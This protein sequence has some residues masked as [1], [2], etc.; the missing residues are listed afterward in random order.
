LED[1][2]ET[3]EFRAP[4]RRRGDD[5]ESK[6]I[7]INNAEVRLLKL[8]LQETRLLR[9]SD[10]KK[11][12]VKIRALKEENAKQTQALRKVLGEMDKLRK[13]LARQQSASRKSE[14]S[15]AS[16]VAEWETKLSKA[17]DDASKARHRAIV[18][19]RQVRVLEEDLENAEFECERDLREKIAELEANLAVAE[20]DAED[21]ENEEFQD[22]DKKARNRLNRKLEAMTRR[23][24]DAE[25]RLEKSLPSRQLNEKHTA[26][27]LLMK[28]REKS[29]LATI[30]K[31]EGFQRS[32]TVASEQIQVLECKIESLQNSNEKLASEAVE[33]PELRRKLEEWVRTMKSSF[34]DKEQVITPTMIA[35]RV[36]DLQRKNA[37]LL[38]FVN[39]SC[40]LLQLLLSLDCFNAYEKKNSNTSR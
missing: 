33:T 21:R 22:D 1:E 11:A 32:G 6:S 34:R 25:S 30:R 29:L 3:E 20:V 17:R 23:A 37:L 39:S 14:T 40:F 36:S 13:S 16:Q 35:S 2:D 7:S 5:M 27:V 19:E 24:E 4:K 18:A 31:L 12:N 26:T 10:A 8:D 15:N 28:R 38:F 9:E